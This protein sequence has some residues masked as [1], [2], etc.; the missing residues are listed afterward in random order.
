M[1][2]DTNNI[3]A[4]YTNVAIMTVNT[5]CLPPRYK[6]VTTMKNGLSSGKT[7]DCNYNDCE[8]QIVLSSHGSQNVGPMLI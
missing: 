2:V 7:Y 8:L 5:A 4:K 6:S 3:A 1:T